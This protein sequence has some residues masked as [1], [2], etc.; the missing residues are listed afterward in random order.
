MSTKNG[1]Y[2]STD[3]GNTFKSFSKSQE[4]TALT[5]GSEDII[6]SYI[7]EQQQGLTKQPLATSQGT[8]LK[9]PSLDSKDQI[10][11]ISQ[12]PQNPAEI[13]FATIKANVFLTTDDGKTWKQ[14][15]KNGNLEYN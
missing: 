11:Y 7:T 2:L 10:M 9:I 6:Y 14:I 5:L 8:D 3:N 12:N 1:I 15:V 4:T 13:V